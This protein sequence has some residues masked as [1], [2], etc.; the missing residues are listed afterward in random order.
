[1]K[2]VMYGM[3]KSIALATVAL[4]IVAGP[5]S[6]YYS[7]LK[8]VVKEKVAEVKSFLESLQD[9]APPGGDPK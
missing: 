8:T 9:E 7:P 1:M 2:T 3:L 6:H 4:T 5:V